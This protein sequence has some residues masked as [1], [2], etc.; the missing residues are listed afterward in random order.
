MLLG[1]HWIRRRIATGPCR[2]EIQILHVLGT[3]E[4]RIEMGKVEFWR[5]AIV[6][7]EQTFLLGLIQ[8]VYGRDHVLDR[9]VPITNG[10]RD[11]LQATVFGLLRLIPV[12]RK[13]RL[14]VCIPFRRT[15]DMLEPDER[16]RIFTTGD[17]VHRYVVQGG[18]QRFRHG[19][20]RDPESFGRFDPV[21]QR[22]IAQEAKRG[23]PP[24]TFQHDPP[25]VPGFTRDNKRFDIEIPVGRDGL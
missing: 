17:R 11:F 25:V 2:T 1:R 20:N 24:V 7:V 5:L 18:T 3:C 22:R 9:V 10:P 15:V 16:T 8:Y 4:R 21:G 23:K 6:D 13:P 12:S 19:R 14:G